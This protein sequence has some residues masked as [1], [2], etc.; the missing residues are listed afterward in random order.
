MQ[1]KNIILGLCIASTLISCNQKNEERT[2]NLEETKSEY[3]SAVSSTAAIEDTKD[4]TRRFVRTADL[5]F[6][7]KSVINSTYDI[8]NIIQQQGGFVT[9]TRLTSDID[10]ISTTPI[11][12]DSLLETTFYTVINSIT[13]RVPNTKLDTTLKEISRNIEYLDHREIKAEDIASQVLTNNLIVKR[14]GNTQ[15]AIKQQLNK[16]IDYQDLSSRTQEQMDNASISNLLLMDQIAYS[17][18]NIFIYQRQ[19]VKRVLIS[20]NNSISAFEPNIGVK[21]VDAFQTGWETLETL[22]VFLVNIWGVL[23]FAIVAYIV[24]KLLRKI[25]KQIFRTEIDPK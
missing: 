20:N 14:S 25:V 5:K 23:L 10:N 9:Y 7:V 13:V 19:D 24:I 8:E 1:I 16:S 4:T 21:L 6:K 12:A 22:I 2:Q 3:N 17:T 15:Q 11:S 18:I